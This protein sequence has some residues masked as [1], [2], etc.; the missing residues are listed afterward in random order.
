MKR[1]FVAVVALG[2][3]ACAA[4]MGAPEEIS[5]P[6]AAIRAD[7]GASP[8]DVAGAI[9]SASARVA[10]VAGPQDAGW[11]RQ[12]ATATDLTLTGP[13]EA[14][15]VRLGFLATE[16]VGDTVIELSYPNGRYTLLDALYEV[17]DK[18]YL[19]LLAFRVE[20]PGEARPLI[21]SL[22][23]YIATDV[24]PDAAV[25]LAVAVPDPAV[26]DS[27]AAMFSPGYY[28]AVRCAS[29]ETPSPTAG[30]RLF[31]GP[32]ARIFCRG[33]SV[34]NTG[35]GEVTTARLVMGRSP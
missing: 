25:I 34:Q 27:V 2:T 19:D 26:G 28:E 11:F 31:Y 30:L 17:K 4:N 5:V 10:L 32:E 13:A 33:T 15:G 12:L 21:A 23:E 18:R 3:A 8:A 29:G 35:I 7:A 22:L 16:A 9:Q 14:D 24:M 6:T 20:K 1:L